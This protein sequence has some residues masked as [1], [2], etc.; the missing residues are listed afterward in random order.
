MVDMV[1]IGSG[2]NDFSAINNFSAVYTNNS[3]LPENYHGYSDATN[4][5]YVINDKHLSDECVG[6]SK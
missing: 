3:W 6:H 1:T 2:Y 4:K 5:Q